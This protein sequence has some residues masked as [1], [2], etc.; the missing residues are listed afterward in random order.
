MTRAPALSEGA[1]RLLDMDLFGDDRQRAALDDLASCEVDDARLFARSTRAL[2]E[3]R[4]GARQSDERSGSDVASEFLCLEVAGT[5]TIAQGSAAARLAQ[6]QHLVVQLPAT[7]QGLHRG[8]LRRLQA[9]VL[10]DE[11]Q[12]LT[13]AQCAQ[14]EQQVLPDALDR[15]P[16]ELRRRVR[17]VVLRVQD[18][19]QLEQE[20]RRAVAERAVSATP[21]PHGMAGVWATMRAEQERVFTSTLRQLAARAKTDGDVRTAAQRQADVLAALPGLV[22]DGLVGAGGSELA[23]AL[24]AAG[25]RSGGRRRDVQAIVLVP[26]H[27]ALGS[28]DEPAELIGHGPITAAHARDLLAAADL[29]TAAVDSAT[30]RLLAVDERLL[31]HDEPAGIDVP[32]PGWRTALRRRLGKP[33]TV[34]ADEEQYRP[35]AGLSRYV[36][37]RDHRCIGVGCHVAA[38]QCD[39]EHRVAWPAGHTGPGNLGPVSRRCHRAK[40]SGWS[41][42]R[43]RDGTT[44]WT[45]PLGRSYRKPPDDVPPPRLPDRDAAGWQRG[46]AGSAG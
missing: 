42:V 39:D 26:A 29:R 7:W 40:Q 35:S 5:C 11:T 12:G 43:A 23:A 27:T 33:F 8:T 19:H 1:A 22:L 25:F 31:S 16:G 34:P 44:V 10:I 18:Q 36:R 24:A 41:Y 45:S 37:L 46:M 20:R 28:S 4:A 21:L 32:E 14:V 2:V 38:R 6:A 30:G 13:P 15:V 3:A 17:R 9:L